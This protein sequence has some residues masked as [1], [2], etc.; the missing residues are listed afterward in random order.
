MKYTK[1]RKHML[2]TQLM[3]KGISNPQVLKA[4]GKIPRH[5]FVDEALAVRAY[6]DYP[7]PIGEGQTI[8]QPYMVALMSEKLNLSGHEKVLEIGTGSGYQTAVLAEL[9]S[10]VFS[11]ELLSGLS[12]KAGEL[13]DRLGYDNIN[14]K[15]ADGSLGWPDAAPYDA[16]IVT[17]G[18]PCTPQPL[19]RQLADTGVLI[20][21]VGNEAHQKL[22]IIRKKGKK[23]IKTTSCPCTFVKLRGALGW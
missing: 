5:F 6:G 7:L 18:A 13:L 23:L 19:I 4:M 22:Q 3:A 9:A 12:A 1:L 2:E 10:E 8:S 11:V 16:I 17:A 15:I 14:F 20:I 21:P